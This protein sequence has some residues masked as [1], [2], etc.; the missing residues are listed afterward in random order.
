VASTIGIDLGGTKTLAVRLDDGDVA[1]EVTLPTDDDL[2]AN[3][4]VAIREVL[5]PEVTAIGVGVAG[6]VS[7]P[8]GVFVWGPHVPGTGVPVRNHLEEL[9]DLPVVVDNDANA[10]A[11]GELRR[12]SGRGYD[13]MLLVTLGTGIG[14]AIVIDGRIHRGTS[15]AGEWGH[16]L[17][18]PG[19]AQCDC[20]KR[21]CW[22]TVASGPALVR[23]ATD[24]IAQ[25]PGSS[26][27]TRLRGEPLTGERITRAADAG[28][29]TARNLV[30]QV[31]EALGR[32]LCN[33][34][35][36]LDPQ[37]VVVGGGLGSV[38][39]SLLAPARRVAA[40]ALHGGS[41]RLLPPIL[42]AGLGP[43]AGA[44]GAALLADEVAA[45]TLSLQ[46]E[47]TR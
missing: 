33:L 21:G 22:E 31:G 16:M 29:E 9:F 35:A 17:Y 37:V 28:D 30:A 26:L 14:G 13:D 36:I 7:W 18:Q 5:T 23:I 4:A 34:I 41:H 38:G 27:S 45:G 39:E 15:F 44:I 42:V 1:A 20:G 19:G 40:D 24:F 43:A 25:N 3:A 32:G 10:S 46:L 2:L 11:W 8:S 12:G 6:L 47:E